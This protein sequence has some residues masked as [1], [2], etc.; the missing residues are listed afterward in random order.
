MYL[1]RFVSAVG[2]IY[3]IVALNTI[4]NTRHKKLCLYGGKVFTIALDTTLAR[5]ANAFAATLNSFE[6]L[7]FGKMDSYNF[8]VC[9]IEAM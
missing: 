4:K 6:K 1:K 9:T 3:Q 8:L 7:R 5:A 2:I